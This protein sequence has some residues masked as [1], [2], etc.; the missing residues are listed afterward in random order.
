M[1]T[2]GNG[3]R[4]DRLRISSNPYD[5]KSSFLLVY[6]YYDLL[7]CDIL[8]VIYTVGTMVRQ[9][10]FILVYYCVRTT[11]IRSIIPY[12][13]LCWMDAIH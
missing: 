11:F 8:S 3:G 5:P 6:Y 12:F 4:G 2:S 13:I 10:L 7:P 1:N 9:V